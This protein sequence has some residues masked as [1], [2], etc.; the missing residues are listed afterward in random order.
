[1][2]K[3]FD[4]VTLELRPGVDEKE[5]VKFFNEQYAPLALRLGFKGYVLKA[6]RGERA[7]KFAV[8]WEFPSVEQRNHLMPE[9]KDQFTEEALRLLGPEFDELNNKLDTFVPD[10][11]S[12]DYIV[13]G[14]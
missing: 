5:F 9:Q 14:K 6:D 1:M 3:I 12:T 8:I 13:Q 7:G 11:P 4:V 2:A 10:W